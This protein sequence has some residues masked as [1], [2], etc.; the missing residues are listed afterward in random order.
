MNVVLFMV[1]F[2]LS[3]IKIELQS[4]VGIPLV[5]REL[6]HIHYFVMNKEL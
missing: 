5:F 2:N 6:E 1:I 4:N 3:T